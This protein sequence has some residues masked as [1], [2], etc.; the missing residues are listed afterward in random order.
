[1]AKAKNKSTTIDDA[2]LPVAEQPYVVPDN[3]CWTRV[4]EYIDYATDYVA[5][6]SFATL[7]ENVK[8]YKEENIVLS[9]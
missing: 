1:M 8:I 9:S 4:G 6:G 2:L 3:W 7:K 5:N